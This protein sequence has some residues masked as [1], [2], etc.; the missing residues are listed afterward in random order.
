MAK[1]KKVDEVQERAVDLPKRIRTFLDP[2][3]GPSDPAFR[4]KESEKIVDEILKSPVV[5][6]KVRSI[7]RRH[8]KSS[9]KVVEL[10]CPS[11]KNSF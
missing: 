8:A 11:I 6:D 9:P 4:V 3:T 7:L 10:C 2:K 1:R 5:V